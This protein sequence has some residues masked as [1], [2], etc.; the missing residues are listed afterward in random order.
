[1]RESAV[2]RT[3]YADYL[4]LEGPEVP[5]YEF[6]DGVVRAMSGGTLEHARL[7]AKLM[8]MIGVALAGRPCAVF[9]PDPKIRVDETNRTTYA[10][11]FVVCG[12]IERS[13]V[14]AE[15][16]VNP[17]VIVEVL[18]PSTEAYDRGEKSRHYRLLRSLREY[19]LVSQDEPLVEVWRRDGDGWRLSERGAGQM[20]RLDSL[21]V[22]LSIDELYAN[23]LAAPASS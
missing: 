23:P 3:S 20:L 8:E 22:E 21:D 19:V 15:A 14:D 7:A 17:R 11:L 1:M 13:N 2:E 12:Q 16:V 6:L 9:S 10:D 18:S 4:A 5:R